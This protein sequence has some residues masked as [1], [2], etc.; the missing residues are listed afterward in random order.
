MNILQKIAQES[1][2]EA[3]E[4]I[5]PRPRITLN[6]LLP[7]VN[8]P[9]DPDENLTQPQREVVEICG[10]SLSGKS[11]KIDYVKNSDLLSLITRTFQG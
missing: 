4:R 2:L 11:R 3:L 10:P 9:K 6:D 7:F 8:I 1:G 5:K